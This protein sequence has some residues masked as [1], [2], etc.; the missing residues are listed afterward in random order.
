MGFF[1]AVVDV[2]Y[3]IEVLPRKIIVKSSVKKYF[4]GFPGGPVVE[5]SSCIAGGVSSFPGWRT[6]MGELR[7]HMPHVQRTKNKKQKQYCKKYN[8]HF[9]IG[10]HQ[11][12]SFKERV[13]T[14]CFLLG[15]LWFQA[16]HFTF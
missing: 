13:F 12:K 11:K 5:T 6:K 10:S 3:A 4:W 14:P 15:V 16:V 2:V 7:S 9:K 8:K 1:L